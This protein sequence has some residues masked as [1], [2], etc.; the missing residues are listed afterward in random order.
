MKPK[1]VGL[2]KITIAI[3]DDHQVLVET[4]KLVIQQEE[5][6]QVIGVAGSCAGCLELVQRVTLSVLILD[7]SLPDGDGLS[8]V[9]KINKLSPETNILVLT[10]LSDEDTLMRAIDLGVS[11]FVG[12]N[13]HL[14]ELLG[15][16]RLA[17]QGE[18]AISASLLLGLLGRKQR[19]RRQ[20]PEVQKYETLTPRENEILSCL[21]QGRS[22]GEIAEMLNIS[23][24]TV[25]THI[26]NLIEKLGVHSRLEAVTYAMQKGLI[27][28]PL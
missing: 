3:I 17:S 13:Q 8:L 7:V 2:E 26:R 15:A 23:P 25:R 9:S 12:K 4:L 10:S 27:D 28:S 21:A 6:M 5:D 16:I 24:L 14:S 18:I 20:T 19:P 11:G 1:T 22:A